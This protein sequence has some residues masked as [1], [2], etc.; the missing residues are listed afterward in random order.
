MPYPN[1]HSCRL[2]D[3]ELALDCRRS[4]R[5]SDGKEYGIIN[6]RFQLPL[7]K[8]SHWAE[9][10][11]RY[12]ISQW[13]EAQA[14]AHCQEHKGKFEP[15]KQEVKKIDLSFMSKVRKREIIRTQDGSAILIKVEPDPDSE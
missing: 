2:I 13:T 6:C 3:P 9:Q 8:E 4:S 12:P 11:Y 14:K 7:Y 10:A 1:E 15:A 5:I